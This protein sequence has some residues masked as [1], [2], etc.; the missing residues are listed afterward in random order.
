M[1]L[2]F[3]ELNGAP[4]SWKPIDRLAS[5]AAL[6]AFCEVVAGRE[7]AH[8]FSDVNVSPF[9]VAA[10]RHFRPEQSS[11]NPQFVTSDKLDLDQYS[12]VVV[13]GGTT[14]FSRH[15]HHFNDTGDQAIVP[16]GMTGGGATALCS[17]RELTDRALLESGR[18]ALAISKSLDIPLFGPSYRPR[19]TPNPLGY[20]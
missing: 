17:R 3:A 9:V 4:A 8:I 1:I 7:D 15:R 6:I 19:P 2:L 11:W 10:N 5:R 13:I 16:L 20:A 18:F 14:E 12:G